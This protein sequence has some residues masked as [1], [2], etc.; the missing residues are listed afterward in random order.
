MST[1]TLSPEQEL[2]QDLLTI[3]HCF[4]SRVYGWRNYR[5][6]LQKAIQDDQSAQDQASSHV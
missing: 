2:V 6:A 1:E 4:S 5:K 3:T